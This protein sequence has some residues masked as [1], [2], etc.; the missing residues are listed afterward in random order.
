MET[1]LY[2]KNKEVEP[3]SR[4][5]KNV[6]HLHF[7]MLRGNLLTIHQSDRIFKSICKSDAS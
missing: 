6:I 1:Y 2:G 3:E 7:S 5:L 4:D